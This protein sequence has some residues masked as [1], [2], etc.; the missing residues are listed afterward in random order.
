MDAFI[1]YRRKGG[2]DIAFIIHEGLYKRRY[3]AFYD[4]ENI[5]AGRFDERIYLDIKKSNNFILIVT[6]GAFERCQEEND[7]VRLEIQKALELNKLIIPV[8]VNG[9]TF[10]PDLP[11][12]IR[13]AMHYDGVNYQTEKAEDAVS[14]IIAYLRDENG[15]PLRLAKNK[16][17]SNTYYS[18]GM[19]DTEKKRI[20]KDYEI[21]KPIE[22][23]IFDKLFQKIIDASEHD[24]TLS[25]IVVFNPA[26]YEISSTM[27]K[28]QSSG[29]TQIYGFLGNQPDTDDANARFGNDTCR[30]Y[31][32][33]MEH[34]D[35]EDE[36]DMVLSKNHL[37]GFDFVDLTLIL[38]DCE[39]PLEKLRAI[40]DRLNENGI[41]YVREL[42]DG[43]VMTYPDEHKYFRK[44]MEYLKLDRYAGNRD[45]GRRTFTC[46]KNAYLED[47]H[48][49]NE[50]LTTA[51]MNRKECKKL[52]DTYFSYVQPELEDLL[53]E[54]PDNLE[55]ENAINWLEENYPKMER[56]FI[57]SESYFVSGFMFFY[58]INS[59]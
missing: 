55:Y 2:S 22:Q 46:M 25:D 54:E 14:D 13:P 44:M 37:K 50:L 33:N 58:G 35:F 51:N 26:I 39:N 32:G 56:E 59:Y 11:E 28:Y 7:W 34:T 24:A 16:K 23:P 48:Q 18:D 27:E 5:Q 42:D 12:D 21:C 57:S 40:V 38:K 17:I 9:A 49:V 10:P 41:V 45:M 6:E 30:F 53:Q 36:L 4:I 47:V 52:F 1:S 3:Y 8:F 31:V 19:S 43:L 29:I 15:K 20:I